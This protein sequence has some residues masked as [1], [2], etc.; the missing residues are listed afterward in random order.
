MANLH[1]GWVLKLCD[2]TP[3][4]PG[5]P[6]SVPLPVGRTV[7]GRGDQA[8]VRLTASGELEKLVSRVHAT[9]DV[10]SDSDQL[11]V[12]CDQVSAARDGTLH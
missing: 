12:L 10:T 7:I 3:E 5:R 1:Q 4:R 11:P 2:G 8:T 9:I 6:A